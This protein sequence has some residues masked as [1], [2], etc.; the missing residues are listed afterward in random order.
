MVPLKLLVALSGFAVIVVLGQ[1]PEQD[2]AEPPPLPKKGTFLF[3]SIHEQS[4]ANILCCDL[5]SIQ[6]HIPS[7]CKFLLHLP[8]ISS[9]HIV[10]NNSSKIVGYKDIFTNLDHGHCKLC[11]V[12]QLRFFSEVKLKFYLIVNIQKLTYDQFCI[13]YV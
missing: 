10:Y 9:I 13:D 12:E 5:P 11:K 8:Y 1:N 3:S 2:F 4:F 6:R 7:T